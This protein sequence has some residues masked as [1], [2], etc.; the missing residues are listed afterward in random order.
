MSAWM[1]DNCNHEW[2]RLDTNYQGFVS[3]RVHSWLSLIPQSEGM[4]R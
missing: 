4:L 2:T 1:G 3:I